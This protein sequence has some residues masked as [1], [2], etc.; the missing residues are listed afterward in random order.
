MSDPNDLLDRAARAHRGEPRR[1]AESPRQEQQARRHPEGPAQ[2]RRP[3]EIDQDIRPPEM[4]PAEQTADV[5]AER[6]IDETARRRQRTGERIR[7]GLEYTVG[8][9][10]SAREGVDRRVGESVDYLTGR[11]PEE[12]RETAEAAAEEIGRAP[13][14]VGEAARR[15][16]RGTLSALVNLPGEARDAWTDA[17][18]RE[19]RRR[20]YEIPREQIRRRGGLREM[21]AGFRGDEE[22]LE[23]HSVRRNV[24]MAALKGRDL[25]PDER[26]RVVRT[27]DRGTFNPQ[28]LDAETADYLARQFGGDQ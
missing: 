4:K 2:Q 20:E 19:R 18:R 7:R 13:G 14:R 24:E 12:H 23:G 3:V 15:G 21:V 28:Q 26:Q 25:T 8:L 10:R 22:A 27:V 16:V 6:H 11:V 9:A 5:V 17:R 1:E